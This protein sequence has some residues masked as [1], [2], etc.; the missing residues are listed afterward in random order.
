MSPFNAKRGL[1]IIP[2]E[3][4]GPSGSIILRLALD[5]GA[6]AMIVNVALLTAIGYDPAL[7]PDRIEVTTGSGVV[8]APRV[9][10]NRI[11]ALGQERTCFY[12]L[13]HTLP[14]S[15]G[16]DGLLGLD[17]LRQ[18]ELHIDFRN[19]RLTLL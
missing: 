15:A 7:A 17:F 12:V 16:V 11:K 3:F 14:P 4:F 1:I 18:Q 2:A 6:T 5:T 13:A 9:E 19:G 10:V 8:Y